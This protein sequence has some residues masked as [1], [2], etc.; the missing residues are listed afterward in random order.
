MSNSSSR[1]G[2]LE[3]LP[4]EPWPEPLSLDS[5]LRSS[6]PMDRLEV[7][8]VGSS[9]VGV[10]LFPKLRP[11]AMLPFLMMVLS[12]W[13]WTGFVRGTPMHSLSA[14]IIWFASFGL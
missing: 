8:R 5:M 4:E 7:V 11:K 1:S 12:Y 14:N 6:L 3:F 10:F 9:V 13:K 2:V